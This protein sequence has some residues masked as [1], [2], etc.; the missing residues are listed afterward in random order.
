MSGRRDPREEE[1]VDFGGSSAPPAEVL[2]AAHAEEA[3]AARAAAADP[4]PVEE[5]DGGRIYSHRGQRLKAT[6][7]FVRLAVSTGMSDAVIASTLRGMAEA[8]MRQDDY[9]AVIMCL[10]GG[11][12]TVKDALPAEMERASVEASGTLAAQVSAAAETLRKAA[13]D[14]SGHVAE[15]ADSAND[16]ISQAIESGVRSIGQAVQAANKDLSDTS[17]KFMSSCRLIEKSCGDKL[18]FNGERA[19][20]AIL[21]AADSL[22][23]DVVS[24]TA[25]ELGSKVDSEFWSRQRLMTGIHAAALAI[26]M[27]VSALAGFESRGVVDEARFQA[28]RTEA[29]TLLSR[30]DYSDV[31]ELLRQNPRLGDIF[32]SHCGPGGDGR[33]EVSGGGVGCRITVYAQNPVAGVEPQRR[34]AVALGAWSLLGGSAW[35][36]A[37]LAMIG[38][39]ALGGYALTVKEKIRPSRAPAPVARKPRRKA[40][41]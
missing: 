21:A 1:A 10:L 22:C 34:E 27:T 37:A 11:L 15:V 29:G 35:L 14:A 30:R 8:G 7:N 4:S 6:P 33:T 17:S 9:S 28:D 19:T 20:A 2:A 24:K 26:G 13:N 18:T 39:V 25:H 40:A 16:A 12:L 31:A 36:A 3:A 41:A 38:G 5:A 23:I 32:S